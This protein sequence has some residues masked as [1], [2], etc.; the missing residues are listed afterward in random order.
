MSDLTEW[1]VTAVP[2]EYGEASW[3][4]RHTSCGRES[5]QQGPDDARTVADILTWIGNHVCVPVPTG[6]RA[7]LARPLTWGQ[8]PA[9][10]YVQP[11]DG[12]AWFMVHG[13]ARRGDQQLVTLNI[14]ETFRAWPRDPAGWVTACPGP[15]SATDDALEALGFPGVL[16]DGS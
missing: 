2:G 9:G 4:L 15:P 14:S 13:T 16:E 10:W 1:A 6:P 8:V 3:T 12:D 5:N 7:T 11:P